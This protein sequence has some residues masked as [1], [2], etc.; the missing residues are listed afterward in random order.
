ME[1]PFI[2]AIFLLSQLHIQDQVTDE[3]IVNTGVN[4][5]KKFIHDNAIRIFNLK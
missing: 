3:N 4:G 2:L 5:F 1:R